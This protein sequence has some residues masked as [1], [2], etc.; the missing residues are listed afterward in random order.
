MDFWWTAINSSSFFFF[1]PFRATPAAY[2][3]S[4][5]RV[6]SELQLPAYTTTTVT[7]APSCLCDLHHSSWQ[8]QILNPLSK[9]RDQNHILMNTSQV[10]NPPSHS[11]NSVKS[12]YLYPLSPL[13][14]EL[15]EGRDFGWSYSLLYSEHPKELLAHEKS[16]INTC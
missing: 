11:G 2:G 16:S 7:P 6:E 14:Q 5:T 9:A 10:L 12:S 4:Q 15:H 13:E 8:R 1:F 3:S